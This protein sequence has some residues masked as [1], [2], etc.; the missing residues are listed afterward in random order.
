MRKR[1][2]GYADDSLGIDLSPMIDCI[3]ILLIFFIVTTVFIEEPG[4]Q[5]NKPDLGAAAEQLDKNSILIAVTRDDKVVYANK[6]IGVKGVSP[7]IKPLLDADSS[8]PVIIQGDN[9]A[10]HGIVQQVHAEAKIAGAKFV[11]YSAKNH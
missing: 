4:A 5:I 11:A 6:T 3:F 1:A 2:A 8:I 7:M 10:S 9:D